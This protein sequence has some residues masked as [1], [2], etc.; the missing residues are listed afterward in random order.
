ML[1]STHVNHVSVSPTN[2]N[3]PTQGQRKTLTRVGIEPTSDLRVR[4]PLLYPL[5]YKVR[6]EQVVG[7]EDVKF[8]AMN[9]YKYKEG[10]V[11]A[12]VGRVALYISTAL[13]LL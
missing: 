5:S 4:S 2:G 11:F 1:F 9:M 13:K 12:N 8:M 6:R 7:I 10:Y 3:G